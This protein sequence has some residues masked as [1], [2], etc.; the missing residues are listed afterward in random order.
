MVI[1]VVSN[2]R[3][4]L[5]ASLRLSASCE[6]RSAALDCVPRRRPLRFATAIYAQ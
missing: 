4:K 5:Q 2:S 3:R 1:R 6:G